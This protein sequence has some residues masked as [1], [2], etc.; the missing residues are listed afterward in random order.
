MTLFVLPS[1]SGFGWGVCGTELAKA[2][3]AI[4]QALP[5]PPECE[6][7]D[8]PF[9]FDEPLVQAIQGV[10]LLPIRTHVWSK[11]HNVGL[12]FIEDSILVKRYVPN[13]RRYFDHVA[14]G[15]SWCAR[16][17]R[18]A[19]VKETSAFVQ[20]VDTNLF[21]PRPPAQN[22]SEC[23][24]IYSGGKFEYRKAQDV[25]IRAVAVMMQR[26]ADVRLTCHWHNPW[27]ATM[28][29]MSASSLIKYSGGSIGN[30]LN[31]ENI[32][33]HKVNGSVGSPL[34]HEKLAEWYNRCD[35]GLFP[36]R[37]EAG[38]NL[39]MMEFMACGKPVIALNAHGHQDV[40]AADDPLLLRHSKE[41]VYVD[42]ARVPRGVWYEPNLEET[43]ER[44]EW[45]YQ[46]RDALAP[47]GAR[48]CERMLQFTWERTARELLKICMPDRVGELAHSSS[49]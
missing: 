8:Y 12:A 23:F 38:T 47:L 49:S 44:L 32:P 5:I 42:A 48:N 46:N 41:F 19:G 36:N 9:A 24:V 16:I 39:V 28:L 35:V 40:L 30:L 1:G 14:A 27:P 11:V 25:V 45:A 17:L 15:S 43:I 34:R 33:S 22:A 10:N 20:G 21:K 2:F 37:C 31:K 18:E 6:K 29:S 4:A 3:R 13:S 26:H 7:T